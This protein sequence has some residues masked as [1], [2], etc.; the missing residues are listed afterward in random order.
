MMLHEHTSPV[1]S[2][3]SSFTLPHLG[4]GEAVKKGKGRGISC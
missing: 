4:M 2:G 3:V 1:H